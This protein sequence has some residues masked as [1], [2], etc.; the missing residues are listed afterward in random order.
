MLSKIQTGY[1]FEAY[2]IFAG[3]HSIRSL[4][5]F[6]HILLMYFNEH[7]YLVL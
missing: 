1:K 2:S 5:P 3:F 7:A 4:A 6:Y